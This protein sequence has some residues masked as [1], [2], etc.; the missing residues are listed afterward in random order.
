MKALFRSK[1]FFASEQTHFF[2]SEQDTVHSPCY[3]LSTMASSDSH[4]LFSQNQQAN[5]GNKKN[6]Q[7][8]NG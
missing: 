2:H 8:A 3:S 4:S 7:Q 1:L 5:D 6:K